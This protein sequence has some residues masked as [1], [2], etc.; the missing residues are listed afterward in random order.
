MCSC[1][2]YVSTHRYAYPPPTTTHKDTQTHT[3]YISQVTLYTNKEEEEMKE[4]SRKRGEEEDEA[5]KNEEEEEEMGKE[6]GRKG[7]DSEQEVGLDYQTSR[8]I[9]SDSLFL[10]RF[11]LLKFLQSFKTVP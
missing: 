3:P 2:L 7:G 8:P 5:E 10:A 6:G 11:H 1:D 9:P 4:V